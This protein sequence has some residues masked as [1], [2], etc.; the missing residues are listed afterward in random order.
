MIA[1][2][3]SNISFCLK[4]WEEEVTF[5]FHDLLGPISLS[6][7]FYSKNF[8]GVYNSHLKKTAS[9]NSWNVFNYNYNQDEDTTPDTIMNNN[10]SFC[11]T[12][13]FSSYFREVDVSFHCLFLLLLSSLTLVFVFFLIF[14]VSFLL[15]ISF[16]LYQDW[17]S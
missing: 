15:F 6:S 4:L 3:I 5:L 1:P 2:C 8:S 9:Y 10:L 16:P 14:L 11:F 7:W 12:I 13:L 17:I